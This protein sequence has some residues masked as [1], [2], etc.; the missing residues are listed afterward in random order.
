MRRL[1]W[2]VPAPTLTTKANRKGTALCHPES[3]RPLSVDEYKRVQ[4]FP[5]HWQLAGAM[6]Q[7]YQQI[8]NAVPTQLGKA[9]GLKVV[10][11]LAESREKRELTKPELSSMTESAL[12][13]LRSYARNNQK[14]LPQQ[15]SLLPLEHDQI[16]FA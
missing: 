16:H 9:L 15:S 3:D 11:T 13:K 8:G 5:D 10:H 4:G 2:D 12:R 14:K 6:N 1:S 7:Q